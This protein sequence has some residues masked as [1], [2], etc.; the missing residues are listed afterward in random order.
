MCR[1]FSNRAGD[2][3]ITADEVLSDDELSKLEPMPDAPNPLWTAYFVV[4]MGREVRLFRT[5]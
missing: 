5:W 1:F 4:V 3:V 2:V